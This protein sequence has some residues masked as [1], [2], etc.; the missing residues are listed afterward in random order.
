MLLKLSVSNFAIIRQVVFEPCKGLNIIT[1]ETGAGKS[2]ILDA[3]DLILGARADVKSLG[4]PN[5][6]CVVEG[7]FALNKDK[8]EDFF[9]DND[10]DFEETTIIRREINT[11]GK[12]RSF[13]NDTPV[14]LQQLKEMGERLVSLH[15][16]HENTH[17]NERDFQFNL[18]DAYSGILDEVKQYK[19]R[20]LVFRSRL[21][22]LEELRAEQDQL[23]KEKD[24]LDFLIN[25]FEQLNL[26]E[27]EESQLENELQILSNADQI[28]QV[29]EGISSTLSESESSMV[30]ALTQL[31]NR[32]RAIENVSEKARDLVQRLNS[33]IIEL[34]DISDDSSS[35]KESVV[36]DENRMEQI[37]ERLAS[38][39]H[40]KRKHNVTEFAVLLQVSEKI[41][42]Q[43]IAIGQM[44]AR[45]EQLETEISALR[46]QL[47]RE[48]DALHKQ[49]V[50][51]ALE[52]KSTIETSLKTLE[53]PHARIE[54]ALDLKEE[55]DEHGRSTLQCL[56]SANPGVSPQPL[57]KVA[58]GGELSRLALSIRAIEA[59]NRQLNTLIFDEIDTGVS[60]KVA[61]TIGKMFKQIA[62]SHQVLAITHLPQVAGYGEKHFFVGKEVRNNS[63]N[64]Y[65]KDLNKEERVEELAKMLSGDEA[66]DIAK[67][68]ASELLKL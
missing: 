48:A 41:A 25:E 21:K 38:I 57:N 36:A 62:K 34:K 44:D 53:M 58:S 31:R 15:S 49:R 46:Q 1:G 27:N 61:D 29:A 35:L 4:N 6:K 3:F 22:E 52:L 28:I 5:E 45:V 56:F 64:S 32:L 51:S 30:D 47:N 43:L 23:I 39:Q 2:I 59:G 33:V 10:I 60:G 66:T 68:N 7:E 18:L 12:S 55:L 16:Q 54:F 20:F 65:I 67:K 11:N 24:Y 8:F 37:N 40:L 63:T 50:K 9:S 42:D 19:S 13:I 26:K 17:L 14:S